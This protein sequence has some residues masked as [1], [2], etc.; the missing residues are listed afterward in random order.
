QRF[1]LAKCSDVVEDAPWHVAR[2]THNDSSPF[3]PNRKRIRSSWP[4]RIIVQEQRH[5]FADNNPTVRR[6]FRRLF[7]APVF[8]TLGTPRIVGGS[9]ESGIGSKGTGGRRLWHRLSPTLQWRSGS[10]L[11]SA[12]NMMQGS[13]LHSEVFSQCFLTLT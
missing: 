3:D 1:H 6:L 7:H 12:A 11:G 10:F 4:K 13:P 8:T 9:Y 2:W 5:F